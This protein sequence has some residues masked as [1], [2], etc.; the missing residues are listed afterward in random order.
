[1]IQARIELE[2]AAISRESHDELGQQV[3]AI[4]S[5]GL[6]IARRAA[7]TDPTIAQSARLVMQCA[8]QIYDGMHRLIAALRPLALDQFGLYDALH[9]LLADCQLQHSALRISV[10]LPEAQHAPD[11]ALA[12]A[13]YRVGIDAEA[14]VDDR[15]DAQINVI[16]TGSSRPSNRLIAFILFSPCQDSADPVLE[17]HPTFG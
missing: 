2:R 17:C 1:M 16:S 9:D 11:D 14:A 15:Q 4:K 5:V 12:T 3:T 8:D 7:D 13:V 6:A 10:T